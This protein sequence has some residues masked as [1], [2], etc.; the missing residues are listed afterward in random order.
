MYRSLTPVDKANT[1]ALIT[2]AGTAIS[3]STSGNRKGWSIQNLGTNAVFVREG[4]GAS[5]TVFH[6]VLKG[7]TGQDDGQGGSY[8]QMVGN[9]WQGEVSIAG[10]SPRVTV[11]YYE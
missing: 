2:S 9:V 4:A 1:P 6:H 11:K 5:T 8:E 10:T 7:G 3:A